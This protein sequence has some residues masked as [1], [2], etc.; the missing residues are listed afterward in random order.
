MQTWAHNGE[1]V[2][3]AVARPLFSWPAIDNGRIR[4]H[5]APYG[6][7]EGPY[8]RGP[9]CASIGRRRPP[10]ALALS[11]QTETCVSLVHFGGQ[12]L[13]IQVRHYQFEIAAPWAAG[14]VLD[15]KAANALNQLR[16]QR[17]RSLVGK[18][19]D[20]AQ[21][22]RQGAQGLL[23]EDSLQNI[24]DRLAKAEQQFEFGEG[25]QARQR[26]L[27]TLE[28]EAQAVAEERVD[29]W[30][31]QQGKELAEEERDRMVTEMASAPAIL[32]EA[33]RRLSAKSA[34]A[35]EALAELLAPEGLSP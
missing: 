10:G 1:A 9:E 34:V 29:S 35:Q 23:S 30:A 5:N 21:D 8:L 31:R 28:A 27:G 18:W 11:R 19:V 16:A 6:R 32:E 15:E 7:T 3:M 12:R 33:R 24:R 2:A 14:Q 22:G 25:P 26:A 17:L 13:K 20:K 4:A